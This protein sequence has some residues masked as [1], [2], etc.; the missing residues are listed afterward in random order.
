MIIFQSIQK[1]FAIL[2]INPPENIEKRILNPKNTFGLIFFGALI[3][4]TD[5]FLFYEANTFQEY[6]DSFYA[7]CT[8]ALCGANFAIVVWKASKVI[9]FIENVQEIIRGRE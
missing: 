2:G 5:E 1:Y 4:S 8:I 6:T 7:T 9:E 3:I